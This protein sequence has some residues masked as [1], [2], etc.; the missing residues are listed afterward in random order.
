[1]SNTKMIEDKAFFTQEVTKAF[2]KD[3][4]MACKTMELELFTNLFPK[5]DLSFVQDDVFDTNVN[6]LKV[7][8][9]H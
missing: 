2:L 5:H 8:L 7:H 1:M 3:L 4:E 9:F 6:N